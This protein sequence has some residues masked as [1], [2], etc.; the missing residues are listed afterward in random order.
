MVGLIHKLFFTMLEK[1]FGQATTEA[2][3][4]RADVAPEATFHMG[5]SYSDDE[6]QRLLAAAVEL[7]GLEPRAFLER[8]A[9]ALFFDALRRWP[10][11]FEM[12]TSTLDFLR[13]QP[14]IHN[15]FASGSLDAAA[16]R[17]V[18]DKFRL[19]SDERSVTVHYRSVNR[20][21]ELY[22]AMAQRIARHYGDEVGIEESHCMH[23]GDGKC[24][25]RVELLPRR[26]AR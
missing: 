17:G 16:R 19:E 7:S 20:L 23:R 4:R 6:W 14:L 13:L 18:T 15:S 24:T 12:A 2:V 8:F 11:W 9:D 5:V 3:R 26:E 10:A 21:C 25:L 22:V 1:E